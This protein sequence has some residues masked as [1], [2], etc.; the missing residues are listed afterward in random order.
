MRRSSLVACTALVLLTHV[1]VIIG[2]SRGHASS[3]GQ[4]ATRSARSAF[5]LV[6]IAAPDG[7]TPRPAEA[8][9][10]PRTASASARVDVARRDADRGTDASTQSAGDAPMPEAAGAAVYRPGSD[11]DVPARP[12]SSP[13]LGMLSGL[14]WSGLPMRVRLFIDRDGLVVDTQVLQSAESPDVTERVRQMFLATSFTAGMA[15]G[16][17]V[18]CFKDIEL[19]VGASS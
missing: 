18:P 3:S 1:G 19:N 15:D 14:A 5:S 9:T 8:G 13:D 4:P 10:L 11:L 2:V 12:R 6:R 7:P 17:A 16:R